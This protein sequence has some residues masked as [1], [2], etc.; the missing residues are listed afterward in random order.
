M[1]RMRAKFQVSQLTAYKDKDGKTINEVLTM[2]AVCPTSFGP[3][4]E[5]EDNDFAR[6]SPGGSLSLTIANPEL[7][8]KFKHGD[9]FYMDFTP[10][11]Q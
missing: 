2:H 10:A 7:W 9:K 6:Y 8:D 11:E 5:H 1:T 3:N 4:G